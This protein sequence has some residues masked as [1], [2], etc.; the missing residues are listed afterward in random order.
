MKHSILNLY[1]TFAAACAT[2]LVMPVS[3]ISS[4][5]FCGKIPDLL[6]FSYLLILVMFV[7]MYA[8]CSNA[9]TG[10]GDDAGNRLARL[11]GYRTEK[12]IIYMLGY[13]CVARILFGVVP[14]LWFFCPA[15]CLRCMNMVAV[16]FYGWIL[17]AS[18]RFARTVS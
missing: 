17:I 4:G 14:D 5:E 10:N 18:G 1:S 6:N 13:V 16:A 8:Y 11:S 15:C 7:C 2:V 3:I 9:K 12:E